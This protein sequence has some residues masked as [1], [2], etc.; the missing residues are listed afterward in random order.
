[1]QWQLFHL[2]S[3][4]PGPLD[5]RLWR[6]V[7]EQ[8][9]WEEQFFQRQFAGL[10]D[11][12]DISAQTMYAVYVRQLKEDNVLDAADRLES[13]DST[14]DEDHGHIQANDAANH[15][16]QSHVAIAVIYDNLCARDNNQPHASTVIYDKLCA[17]NTNK[18]NIVDKPC[19]L[20]IH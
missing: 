3:R 16:S 13:D 17:S 2:L 9:F 14:N 19:Q 8:Q 18:P 7:E 15:T 20:L 11:K 4:R 10:A 12:V 6:P 5:H 1:M